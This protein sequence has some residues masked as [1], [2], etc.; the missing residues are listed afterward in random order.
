MATIRT[1]LAA[2]FG[3]IVLAAFG[4]VYLSVV[5]GLEASLT[6]ER[7]RG[8]ARTAGQYAEPIERAITTNQDVRVLDRTVRAAADASTA[9]VTLLG[10]NR[11]TLGLQTF[12]KSD[13]TARTDITDLQFAVA[14]SAARS[15]RV[16]R[17]TEAG[18]EGRVGQA[19]V[20]LFFPG[21]DG[22]PEVGSVVVFTDPLADLEGQVAVVRRRVLVAGLVAALLAALAGA[23]VA[24]L[25]GRRVRRL[26]AVAGLVAAGDFSARFPVDDSDELG[27][28]A[29]TL[30]DM[31]RQLAELEHARSR[32]IAT[33]S[34]ELRT[35]I[36]SLGG[37]VELLQDEDLDDATRATFLD[38]IAQQ[39]DRLG[40]LA[41]DLLDLSKLEAGTLELRPEQT[42]LAEVA[43][44]V[45]SEF[46]PALLAHR[47][48]LEVRVPAGRV[49]A[50]CDPERVAQVLRIL[51]DNALTHTPDG[52]DVVLSASR[53]GERVRVG[54]A[55]FG[56]GIHRTMLPHIFEP[57][58]TSD[59]AQ[60]SGLGLAIAHELAERMSGELIAES[61]PGRT[62][63]T[64][65]LPA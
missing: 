65:E 10:V 24:E 57:F 14:Q 31:R 64:L 6:D 61:K 29:Q 20:P 42:D 63:F 18:S 51:I 39:V 45:A 60:G 34:H 47:S 28:L 38:Q 58:V 43:E 30:E 56:P 8:L 35:P 33:A 4:G 59:D 15:G 13:S 3:L 52:T 36:F 17:G 12:P 25:L 22:R 49:H 53:R 5:P 32:F 48:T 26:E 9:R 7:L 23:V 46:R 1:R 62:T 21:R 27:R 50:V 44:L 11:G 16:E 37:F 19:A 54:V 55:D 2:I 41:T 40:K